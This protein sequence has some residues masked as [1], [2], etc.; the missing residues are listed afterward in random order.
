MREGRR[1]QRDCPS[2]FQNTHETTHPFSS[3]SCVPY[4]DPSPPSLRPLPHLDLTGVEVN[5]DDAVHA[6][7]LHGEEREEKGGKAGQQR[8]N[9]MRS[10]ITEGCEKIPSEHGILPVPDTRLRVILL[11][12]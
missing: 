6:H 7:L 1:G 5:R 10:L 8:G 3:I 11:K 9:T 12:G 4:N 2:A